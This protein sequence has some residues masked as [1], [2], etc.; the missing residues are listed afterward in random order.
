MSQKKSKRYHPSAKPP[1]ALVGGG[2]VQSEKLLLGTTLNSSF[3]RIGQKPFRPERE[4]TVPYKASF[5]NVYVI[6]Q[7]ISTV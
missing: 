7:F 2:L 5:V 6:G 1:S 4:L 3:Y